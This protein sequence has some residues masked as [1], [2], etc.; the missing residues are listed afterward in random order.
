MKYSIIISAFKNTNHTSEC[1]DS[2]LPY[3]TH[4]TECIIIDDGSNNEMA[5]LL[6]SY[7]KKHASIRAIIHTDNKGLIIRRNEG[8]V[9]AKG[10]YILFLDNDTVW[11]GDVL[12]Y[13]N[14]A[15]NTFPNCGIVGM[16]GVLMP[17]LNSSIH[18]H[19]SNLTKAIEVHAVTGYCL[20]AKRE[21][22]HKGVQF[23]EQMTFMLHEDIDF[24][25]E[26]RARGYRVYAVPYVPLVH[27]E[28]GTL[29]YYKA[30][31]S[32]IFAQNWNYFIHK[33]TNTKDL[34]EAFV[35]PKLDTLIQSGRK[36]IKTSEIPDGQFFD[37]Q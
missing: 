19:Q 26:A 9:Q 3:L 10:E 34:T 31:H 15:I 36:I 11:K 7:E 20:F 6:Q 25:F 21:L 13:L 32:R 18:I 28:H 35:M 27:K 37:L 22:L 1:L 16:C 17:S 5:P 23:D 8:I 29:Q 2:L 30:S 12:S 33:W 4:D 24:C 14:H